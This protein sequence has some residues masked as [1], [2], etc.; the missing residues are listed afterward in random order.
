MSRDCEVNIFKALAHPIRIEILKKLQG[1]E[2]CVC[3]LN[4][5][6]EFSQANLSQ[7]LKILRDAK[8][9]VTEKRGMFIYYRIKNI[10][11]MDIIKIA[12]E[13]CHE[14]VNL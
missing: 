2:V 6:I 10:K 11:I 9:V 14:E 7:H 13:L 4:E 1:K 12:S 5:D 3:A 8:I